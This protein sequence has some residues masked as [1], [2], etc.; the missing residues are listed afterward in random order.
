MIAIGS[1]NGRK[2]ANFH[3]GERTSGNGELVQNWT[4]SFSRAHQTRFVQLIKCLFL[5]DIRISVHSTDDHTCLL[6]DD[7]ANMK[8]SDEEGKYKPWPPAVIEGTT[9][10]SVK[11]GPTGGKRGYTA[12]TGKE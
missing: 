1:L 11:I 3:H 4:S 9:N 6:G 7:F 2:E 12:I 10:F 8:S 5:D